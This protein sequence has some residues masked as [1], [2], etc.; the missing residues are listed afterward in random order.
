MSH[1]TV[2]VIGDDPEG[3]LAPFDEDLEVEET[4]EEVSDE[5]MKR[6]LKVYTTFVM[7]RKYGPETQKEANAN[8]KMTLGALYETYGEDWNSGIWFQ[9]ESGEWMKRCS[10]NTQ[11]HWDWYVLG[12]RWTGMLKLKKGR[13]GE[14]GEPG[15]M[16]EEA[17]E[18]FVDQALLKDIDF[19]GMLEEDLEKYTKLYDQF[20]EKSNDPSQKEKVNPFF[21]FGIHNKGTKEEPLWET[22]EEYLKRNVHFSTFAFVINGEWH[23]QGEMGWWGVVMDEKE[24]DVWQEEFNTM[25]KNLPG[26]TLISIYDC[27]I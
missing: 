26:D 8:K 1:F 10:Y 5:E 7:G 24:V 25:L 21:D 9:N 12:G 23:E 2:C 3:Q 27:H 22:K 20:L 18:G 6:F 13:K 16:T 4:L 15:L 11:A 14:Q 17:S 19:D